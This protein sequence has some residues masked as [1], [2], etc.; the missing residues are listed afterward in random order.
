MGASAS[1]WTAT[2]SQPTE[3]QSTAPAPPGQSLTADR[4]YC[5]PDRAPRRP[6]ALPRP[7][8]VQKCAGKTLDR[9]SDLLHDGPVLIEGPR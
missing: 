2:R 6:A 9:A 3:S 7:G 5:F 4:P 1:T 8:K